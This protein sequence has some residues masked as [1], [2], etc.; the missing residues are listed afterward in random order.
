MAAVPLICPRCLTVSVAEPPELGAGGAKCERCTSQFIAFYLVRLKL[1]DGHS[2]CPPEP[3]PNGVL[4]QCAGG[5][6]VVTLQIAEDCG[7]EHRAEIAR[8]A[9][10]ILE[11]V[12]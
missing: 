10:R 6:P 1:P 2:F 11:M 9:Q 5:K 4:V 8:V 12:A 3:R 7:D